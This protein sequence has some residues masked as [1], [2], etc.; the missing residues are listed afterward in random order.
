MLRAQLA[1]L[2]A[3][4]FGSTVCFA[5]SST[6]SDVKAYVSVTGSIV[7]VSTGS[8]A[9]LR[10]ANRVNQLR[11]ILT[12]QLLTDTKPAADGTKPPREIKI[13][14][15]QV[16]SFICSGRSQYWQ[17][18]SNSELLQSINAAL[19]DL[20]KDPDKSTDTSVLGRLWSIG[21]DIYQLV[22]SKPGSLP[23]ASSRKLQDICLED[24]KSFDVVSHPMPPREPSHVE[25]ALLGG[26]TEAIT[27]TLDIVEPPIKLAI[28]IARDSQRRTAVRAFFRKEKNV[29]SVRT[30]VKN[31]RSIIADQNNH[32]RKMSFGN[33]V[34]AWSGLAAPRQISSIKECSNFLDEGIP[35]AKGETFEYRKNAGAE[36]KIT[37]SHS[38][39]FYRCYRAVWTEYEKPLK[40]ALEAASAYD[41]DADIAVLAL[42]AE[43]GSSVA[44]KGK[45]GQVTKK[46]AVEAAIE[47]LR[48]S[49]APTDDLIRNLGDF[50]NLAIAVEKA[51]S[52][53]SQDKIRQAIDKALGK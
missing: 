14:F 12:S 11:A 28:K 49:A 18:K 2:I 52:K 29:S 5:Q 17:L 41:T 38:A 39:N 23:D 45:K 48:S 15:P 20:Y 8:L 43:T 22:V 10:A 44:V 16:I 50:L 36:E 3:F 47:S 42:A 46:D 37:F 6:P 25:K 24:A 53:E 21:K 13:A 26:M 31:L 27:A 35:P 51:A 1:A 9:T 19:T 34:E 30:A 40:A 7:E 33:V 4:V 32:S